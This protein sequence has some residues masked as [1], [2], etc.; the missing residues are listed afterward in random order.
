MSA[1]SN[2][3]NKL[4]RSTMVTIRGELD[5]DGTGPRPTE[6]P[7]EAVY[8]IRLALQRDPATKLN[9]SVEGDET[10]TKGRVWVSKSA[11]AAVELT[12]LPVA[13]PE[14]T[15]GPPGAL[16]DWGGRRYELI[17]DK[18]LEQ[19]F[20]GDGGDPAFLRYRC[21]ERGATPP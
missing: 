8:T 10:A 20:V 19:C 5:Y 6:A 13:P 7:T 14:N 15:D 2:A 4:S 17:E 18:S 1:L 21:E 3:V 11:L 9:R 12:A 16:I